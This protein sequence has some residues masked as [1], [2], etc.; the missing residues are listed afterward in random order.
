MLTRSLVEKAHNNEAG[1]LGRGPIREKSLLEK[2]ALKRGGFIRERCLLV[3]TII[4]DRN[5]LE[6]G[7]N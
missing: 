6:R 4:R 1:L 7:G 2:V 3:R 5:S